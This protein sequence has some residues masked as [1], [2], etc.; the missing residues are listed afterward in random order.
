MLSPTRW[1][2]AARTGTL[3]LLLVALAAT[4]TSA[5]FNTGRVTI[6]TGQSTDSQTTGTTVVPGETSS[7]TSLCRSERPYTT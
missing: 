5:Q 4:P 3:A 7:M 2:R 1:S 6:A